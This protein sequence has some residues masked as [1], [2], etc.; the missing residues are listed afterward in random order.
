MSVSELKVPRKA[1]ILNYC[2]STES[3]WNKNADSLGSPETETNQSSSL[4]KKRR[5]SV[6][7]GPMVSKAI[8]MKMCVWLIVEY[9]DSFLMAAASAAAPG[10]E[11]VDAT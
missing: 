4:Y 5:P 7:I 1:T 8:R 2:T 10:V 11:D 3:R 9:L 6:L